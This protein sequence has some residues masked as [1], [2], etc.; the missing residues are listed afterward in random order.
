M[1]GCK[2]R[3]MEC[4][5]KSQFSTE[6]LVLLAALLAFLALFASVARAGLEKSVLLSK[7]IADEQKLANACAYVRFFSLDGLHA[8]SSRTFEGFSSR[9]V[10]LV[11]GNRSLDCPAR[12]RFEG[13]VLKVEPKALE[14]R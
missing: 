13:G 11:L 14:V 2:S 1:S 3:G 4:V 7:E 6:F 10:K 8:L 5:R 9:G 12:F